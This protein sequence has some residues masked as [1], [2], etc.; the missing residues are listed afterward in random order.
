VIYNY[1]E[2]TFFTGKDNEKTDVFDIKGEK[3]KIEWS[4]GPAD[5]SGYFEPDP[6]FSIMIYDINGNYVDLIST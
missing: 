4:T 5:Y 3:W 6:H 1:K 2:V